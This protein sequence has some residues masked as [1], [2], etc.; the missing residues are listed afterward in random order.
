MTVHNHTSRTVLLNQSIAIHSEQLPFKGDVWLNKYSI[1]QNN[2]HSWLFSSVA[3]RYN[4]CLTL[5]KQLKHLGA[6]FVSP[7]CN[8]KKSL[9]MCLMSNYRRLMDS[10]RTRF[11][12]LTELSTKHSHFT[13]VPSSY[14]PKKRANFCRSRSN[15]SSFI[16][17]TCLNHE[18]SRSTLFFFSDLSQF[19]MT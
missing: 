5:V 6:S 14:F 7:R 18:Y 17:A 3:L 16:S 8:E 10:N 4:N 12:I 1:S 19:P 2:R 13:S 9:F 15:V 11:R